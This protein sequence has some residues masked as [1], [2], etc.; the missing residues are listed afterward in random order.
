MKQINIDADAENERL[1]KYLAR[2]LPNASMGFIYKML[3]KKNIVLNGSKA[4]GSELLKAGDEIKVFFSDETYDKFSRKTPREVPEFRPLTVL[5]EDS[6]IIAV[7]KPAG[8]LSQSDKKGGDCVNAR[9]IS[10]LG[11]KGELSDD[12]TPSIVNRLDRNTSGIVLAGK[13][14]QGTRRLTEEIRERIVIKTYKCICEGDFARH[15][16]V[17]AFLKELPGNQVKIYNSEVDGSKKIITEFIPE[18]ELNGYTLL[19]VILHTG[20]KHQ[21][22][23]QLSALGHPVAGDGKYGKRKGYL[24]LHAYSVEIPDIGVITDPLPDEFRRFIDAHL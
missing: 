8:L 1:N 2:L 23:A 13:T 22:R 17:T 12:F 14:Y 5:Y 21:I 7:H 18:R 3:R 10:Y 6:D 19:K 4:S 11:S 20:R 15:M 9:I 16:T 24:C